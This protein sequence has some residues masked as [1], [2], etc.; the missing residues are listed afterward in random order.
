M[1]RDNR[2]NDYCRLTLFLHSAKRMPD[3]RQNHHDCR[4]TIPCLLWNA[5]LTTPYVSEHYKY[6]FRVA[7]DLYGMFVLYR[8]KHTT[9][10]SVVGIWSTRI[11]YAGQVYTVGWRY[12]LGQVSRQ[13]ALELSLPPWLKP[14]DAQL[15]Y[16]LT[17]RNNFLLVYT[18]MLIIYVDS[19]NNTC[20]TAAYQGQ[21]WQRSY[22]QCIS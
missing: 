10:C 4:Q 12:I 15:V 2:S 22:S 11:S 5:L 9:W 1:L 8:G 3:S 16:N 19:E 13:P 20:I 14:L 6:M 17:F 21:C 7:R 18:K